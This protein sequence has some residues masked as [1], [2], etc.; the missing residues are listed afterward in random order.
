MLFPNSAKQA[1]AKT[2]FDKEIQVFGLVTATNAEGGVTK[3]ISAQPKST[4]KG[5][6]RFLT[7]GE[8]LTEK[9]L[10]SD[11]DIQIS[12]PTDSNVSRDDVLEY[13]GTKYSVV[14]VI[15]YDSHTTVEAKVWQ[16]R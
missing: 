9:G 7:Y 4:L 16:G 14:N 3:T 8:K 6:V 1:F 13:R 11:I 10:V 15:P 5:N 12:L 2:F